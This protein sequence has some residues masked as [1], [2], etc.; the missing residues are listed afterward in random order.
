MDKKGLFKEV[1]HVLKQLIQVISNIDEQEYTMPISVLS[2]SSIGE[3]TRHIIE[4][5]E[6][7]LLAY[8]SSE[9]N[10]DARER[11]HILQQDSKKAI[12]TILYI[13]QNIEKTNKKIQL[14]SLYNNKE[15]IIETNYY[16][17]IM[18]NIEHCIHHQAI[19]KNG[20]LSI[21]KE[22]MLENFGV[23][24]STINYK[25]QCVQ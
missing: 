16:R 21:N 13:I 15:E 24:K 2:N 22:C 10:Y 17:E 5:F 18:Y 14:Y 20:L 12:E 23:A 7:L 3:H 9:L 1:E 6:Q 19:I 25:K 8:S 11:K 4:L